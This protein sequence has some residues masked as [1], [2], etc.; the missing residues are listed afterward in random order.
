MDWNNRYGGGTGPPAEEYEIMRTKFESKQPTGSL[1]DAIGRFV[2]RITNEPMADFPDSLGQMASQ[3]G[4]LLPSTGDLPDPT[5]IATSVPPLVA[6]FTKMGYGKNLQ[7]FIQTAKSA[8][9]HEK[10]Y[11]T[12]VVDKFLE[13]Y[14]EK[15]LDYP[16]WERR[17]EPEDALQIL[18]TREQP[19]VGEYW[20]PRLGKAKSGFMQDYFKNTEKYS[21]P[22]AQAELTEQFKKYEQHPGM[23]SNTEWGAGGV[24]DAIGTSLHE[25]LHNLAFRTHKGGIGMEGRKLE[26]KVVGQIEHE[27]MRQKPSPLFGKTIQDYYNAETASK[28]AV[29]REINKRK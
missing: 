5:G 28:E 12:K 3:A 9:P 6:A 14:P 15:A 8:G 18:G 1:V 11:L 23:F 26:E 24:F 27:L 2:N 22:E 16:K 20:A 25:L 19:A 17:I 13:A 29:V 7:N 21:T 10:K 4:E